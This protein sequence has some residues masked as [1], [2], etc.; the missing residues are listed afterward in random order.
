MDLQRKALNS[1]MEENKQKNAEKEDLAMRLLLCC[2]NELY[3][4]FPYLDGA[5]ASLPGHPSADA[6]TV[7]TDGETLLFCPSYLISVFAADPA[8]LRRGYL[9]LLLHCLY[10]HPFRR[11]G[12]PVRRWNLA[13]DMAVEQIL[14][15]EAS[16]RLEVPEQPVKTACLTLLGDIPLDA[17]EIC[18][19]L[20]AG[21]F[22]YQT[23]AMEAAFLFDDHRLW[24]QAGPETSKKWEHILAYTNQSRQQRSK[25][26]GAQAG[27]QQE[28]VNSLRPGTYDYRA[29]LRQFAVLREER[30][31]DLDSFDYIYY[32]LGMEYYGNLPLMEPLEYREGHKLEE[33]VIAIDTSGS[34]SKEIV[35]QFLSE[36]YAILSQRENFFQRMNVYLIQCDCM[37]QSVAVIHSEEEWKNY[38]RE[39]TIV[40]RSG[41]DFTPVFRYVEEQRQKGKLRKLKALLYFTDGD[42]YFPREKPDYETA[43]VFLKPTEQM[44]AVPSWATVLLTQNR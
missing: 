25:K 27:D 2:R 36:T 43:F 10:L 1:D 21:A 44:N 23:E 29:Y 16:P 39:I 20:E 18:R 34:C 22:P 3:S 6:A 9:H 28:Q 33:L 32:N 17:A 7:G 35:Q 15:K 4:L 30:E 24:E 42:G 31:M 12:Q 5:F 41:T 38:S 19:M 40:G 26:R 37:V 14:Q 8:I 11:D 13:C